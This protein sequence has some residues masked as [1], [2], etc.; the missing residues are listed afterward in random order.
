MSTP[1]TVAVIQARV[2]STRFPGKVLA[3]LCGKPMLEHVIRRVA[4]AETLDAV[5]VATTVAS[6]DDVVAEL[7]VA[8]GARATRGSVTD[9][10]SRFVLAAEEHDADVVVRVT[11]DSPLVDPALVD[12]LVRL[13]VSEGADY[14]SNELP[15]T[16]PQGYDLEVLTA[17]CLRRLDAEAVMDYHREHVTALLR[18]HPD[19]YRVTNMTNERD[20]SSIRLTVDVPADLDRIRTILTALPPS[21]P[22]NL[23]AVI[24]YFK[25]DATLQDQSALPARDE[26]YRAQRDAAQRRDEPPATA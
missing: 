13:R 23:A 4:L 15:P 19:A 21:P 17:E 16:Y 25:S 6:A 20:L 5:V 24:A 8:C 9:V 11:S 2:G 10:L 14:A 3:D 18:E 12:R 1:R 22:P 7:A 26:R